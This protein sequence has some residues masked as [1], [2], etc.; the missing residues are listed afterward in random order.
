MTVQALYNELSYVDHSREKR[1]FYAKKVLANPELVGNLLQIMFM[2][3]D[4]VSC[5]AAWVLEFVCREKLEIIIPHLNHFTKNIHHVHLDPAVRPV[6]KIC[7]CLAEA[8]YK[9]NKNPIKQNLKSAHI[10][11]I[12]EF[13]LDCLINDEKVAPKAHSM[14][15]LFLF[16]RDYN[17][18]H[19]ELILILERDFYRQSAAFKARARR[20][21]K[22]LKKNQ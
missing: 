8:Y 21:L 4:K 22:K 13:C 15:V 14:T 3:N 18:I 9:N 1:V 6:A 19:P 11:H 12:I 5:R 7:E 10:D 17:W 20:I 16:G 2:V